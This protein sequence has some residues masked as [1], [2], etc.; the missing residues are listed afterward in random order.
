MPQTHHAQHTIT[1]AAP[2]RTVYGIVE[3]A[4]S[5]PRVF[6]PSV[7]VERTPVNEGEEIIRIWATANGE[8]KNWTSR[9]RLDPVGLRIAFRQEVSQ[10]PVA[11]MGGDWLITPLTEAS[12]EVVLNHDFT[13]VDDD[14]EHV[15]WITRAMDRN[16]AAELETL[17]ATAEQAG[18]LPELLLSFEDELRIAGSAADVH[19]FVWRA[20]RWEERLPHVARVELTEPSQH[21]QV[22]EMDTKAKDGSQ[23]TTRSI[24]VSFAPRRI[25]YKQLLVPALMTA[26]T[27]EWLLREE[28]GVTTAT[29]RHTVVLKPSAVTEV[30]GARATVAD[31]R[32]LVRGALSANSLTTLR[33]AK[34]F[35]ERRGVRAAN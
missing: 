16:S 32:E 14:P 15:S 2:A 31:A 6:P 8:V 27:G 10:H 22:L 1:V 34:E 35:A 29:S 18:R 3:D 11:S 24:R 19:E 5:W 23:H 4:A 25:V 30:L 12:C 33:H 20:D 9:R 7:H 21:T 26:H 28:G 13:A 17:K